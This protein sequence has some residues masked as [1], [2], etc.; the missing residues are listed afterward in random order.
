[1]AGSQSDITQRK[2]AEN[3]LQHEAFYDSLTGLPNRALFFDRLGQAVARTKRR[4]DRG[5]GVLF[6]EIDGFKQVNDSLGHQ[7]GDQLLIAISRRLGCCMR[8]ADT[9]ARVGGRRVH[10]LDRRRRNRGDI[11]SLPDRILESLRTPF[12][13]DGHE[14]VVSVRSESP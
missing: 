1:M 9:V 3:R 14:V 2:E 12:S 11:L 8:E 6:L 4:P 10:R 7:M 5:S 13:L